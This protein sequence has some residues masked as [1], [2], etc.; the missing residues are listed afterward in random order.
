MPAS[1][2]RVVCVGTLADVPPGAVH[3]VTVDGQV[4]VVV[5]AGGT[6]VAVDGSCGHA[7]GPLAEGRIVDDC[8][9]RCPWHGATYDLR[10]GDACSGPARKSIR[11][12]PVRV[13]DGAVLLT[14]E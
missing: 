8:L 4:I 3:P 1:T 2:A 12:Y 13:E 7:G 5:N 11:R 10:T 9:L 6:L 14:L